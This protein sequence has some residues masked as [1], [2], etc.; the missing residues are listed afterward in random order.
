M[1]KKM[2]RIP[3]GREGF[4]L[5]E[6]LVVLVIAGFLVA[7]V[8]PRL[9]GVSEYAG[10]QINDTN[11]N[12][13]VTSLGAY[14][15]KTERYPNYLL[16]LVDEEENTPLPFT[17]QVPRISDNDSV[18]GAETLSMEFYARNHLHIHYLN[19]EEAVELR[20]MGITT[21][22]NLNEYS[23][24]N[25]AGTAFTGGSDP[26]VASVLVLAVSRKELMN[27]A[28]V[29]AGL[30]VAMIGMGIDD[31]GNWTASNVTERGWGE[32]DHFGRIV[33]GIGPE[34]TLVSSGTITNAAYSPSALRN[35]RNVTYNKYT[36]ILPRL[37]A[38][39]DRIDPALMPFSAMD[40]DPAVT[41]VQLNAVSYDDEPTANY[42]YVMNTDHF[43]TRNLTIDESQQWWRY[44]LQSPEGHVYPEDD[45]ELWGIDL[46][47][48]NFING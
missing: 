14:L 8:S 39:V 48:N 6:I 7:M 2:N 9:G 34:S 45:G 36:L 5:L 19:D 31:T 42:D 17:Y 15:E 32:P 1:K 43:R 28:D 18:N 12:R 35:T 40:N 47:G 24:Q 30:G 26:D 3:T 37:R 38:T 27:E 22:R 41:G 25:K 44:S 29:V 4:S 46:N 21:L 11:L 16:N 33:L 23:G 20:N 13:M 10:E